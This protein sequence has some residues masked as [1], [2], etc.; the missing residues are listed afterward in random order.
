MARA[1]GPL[2]VLRLHRKFGKIDLD[3]EI[4]T[5]A[6]VDTLV[7]EAVY[8][9]SN[10]LVR[11]ISNAGSRVSIEG[12]D[13]VSCATNSDGSVT[14][15]FTIPSN[16]A[17]TDYVSDSIA[18]IPE[19][20]LSG[21]VTSAEAE[22]FVTHDDLAAMDYAEKDVKLRGGYATSNFWYVT[23][24]PVYEDAGSVQT[25]G[26]VGVAYAATLRWPVYRLGAEAESR[27]LVDG[28]GTSSTLPAGSWRLVSGSEYATLSNDVVRPKMVPGIAVVA[29]TPTDA[30]EPERR[31]SLPF[32]PSGVGSVVRG[33]YSEDAQTDRGRWMNQ[34]KAYFLGSLSTPLTAYPYHG[35]TVYD[36]SGRSTWSCRNSLQLYANVQNPGAVN[37]GFFNQELGRLL[38]CQTA[39]RSDQAAKKPYIAVSPHYAISVKHWNQEND[40]ALWCTNRSP[41]KFAT[42]RFDGTSKNRSG[43][44]GS[45]R[46]VTVHRM[47]DPFPQHILVHFIRNEELAKVSPSYFSHAVAVELSSHN[48][49]HP[50]MVR[51]GDSAKYARTDEFRPWT[52]FVASPDGFLAGYEGLEALSHSIHIHESGHGVY[53]WVDGKLILCGTFTYANGGPNAFHDSDLI[54]AVNEIIRKDSGGAESLLEY[55]ANDFN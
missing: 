48:T 55:T 24:S 45:V 43:V 22:S 14:Y 5:K 53:W 25:V 32:N 21:Y 13:C 20:D 49:V 42:L 26:D 23:A 17:T 44:V 37:T 47:R 46:D 33:P 7:A 10:S 54:D 2:R 16:I 41:A 28:G 29:Y 35:D 34:L 39:W 31:I 11:Q 52:S 6:G 27:E 38:M 30:S 19:T 15:T 4:Y 50:M 36:A 9:V 51:P 3:D 40:S 12:G 18:A 1:P 8:S